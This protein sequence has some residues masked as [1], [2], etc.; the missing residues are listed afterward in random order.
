M[1]FL[2]EKLSSEYGEASSISEGFVRRLVSF[3]INPLKAGAEEVLGAFSGHEVERVP[4][5]AE[6]FVLHAPQERV[7]ESAVYREGKIYLQSLSSMLP[8][9]LL[10]PREGENILDMAAA[11]GGKTCELY[12]LSDGKALITACERD[13]IRFE[14][15]RFNLA[16]QGATRI[17]AVLTD[18]LKLDDALK[19]DKVLL[20]APCS[21]SGTIVAGKPYRLTEEYLGKCVRAQTA[22]LKK[23]RHPCLFHLLDSKRGERGGLEG[24][25]SRSGRGALAAARTRCPAPSLGEKYPDRAPD[26]ALRGLFR[27][28]H[29]KNLTLF[30]MFS[31]AEA[32]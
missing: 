1:D 4:W 13:K 8:P 25:P 29:Q 20:D 31:R 16:R 22:L 10:A 28:A 15:L 27:G 23:G 30:G 3:R 17:N 7:E 18:A 32:Y 19:F 24:R 5:Y 2:Q 14:R 21:G 9:L 11:P 6:A 12:A 26:F